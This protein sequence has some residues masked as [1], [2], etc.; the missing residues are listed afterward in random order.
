MDWI[1]SN[2]TLCIAI[3]WMLEK[4]TKMTTFTQADDILIDVIWSGIKK[5][6]KK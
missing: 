1:A 5:A 3:F 4:I 6:L 2:W